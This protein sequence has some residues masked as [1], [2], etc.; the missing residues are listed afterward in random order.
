M[1]TKANVVPLFGRRLDTKSE[2]YRLDPVFERS[3]VL[4][5]TTRPKLWLALGVHLDPKALD[6]PAATL[7]VEA[8][9]T[10]ASKARPPTRLTDVLQ[11]LHRLHDA[12]KVTLDACASVRALYEQAMD[13][14]DKLGQGRPPFDTTYIEGIAP[15]LRRRLKRRAVEAA[16]EDMGSDDGDLTRAQEVIDLYR[17]FDSPETL[18]AKSD[19]ASSIDAQAIVDIMRAQRAERA[20]TGI[21]EVDERLRGGNPRGTLG[22]WLGATGVGKSMALVHQ[23]VANA[24]WGKHVVVLTGELSVND[25]R[26][27]VIANLFGLPIGAV[28]GDSSLREELLERLENMESW[29]TEKFKLRVQWFEPKVTC[30]R[31][32]YTMVDDIEDRTGDAVDVVVIDYADKLR[33][34]KVAP[35]ED[36]GYYAAGDVYE[37]LRLWADANKRWVWTACQATREKGRKQLDVEDVSDSIEKSRVTDLLIAISRMKDDPTMYE[38]FI[39]KFRH[40]DDRYTVGP[41][42]SDLACARLAPVIDTLYPKASP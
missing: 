5:L 35:K 23:A 11:E 10:V 12:G 38:Y 41:L 31:D 7:A 1:V 6:H 36:K 8:I 42:P 39:A 30:P 17:R 15:L 40:G 19:E 29:L 2:P 27:R 25:W 4:A 14:E 9:S 32:V 21:L 28:T 26:T 33:P 18:M 24:L 13:D 3:L 20:G 16:I 22:V 37:S 34:N